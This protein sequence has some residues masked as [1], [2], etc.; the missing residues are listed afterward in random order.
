[1]IWEA[2]LWQHYVGY[3]LI[4]HFMFCLQKEKSSLDLLRCYIRISQLLWRLLIFIYACLI[5][6][7][8]KL[9][10]QSCMSRKKRM[11]GWQPASAECWVLLCCQWSASLAEVGESPASCSCT[12]CW[13]SLECSFIRGNNPNPC[14]ETQTEDLP[15]P[16]PELRVV[17]ALSLPPLC[18]TCVLI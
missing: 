3:F 6:H 13:P 4:P 11:W 16:K 18:P 1:M 14:L 9:K 2:S 10:I 5:A 12:C 8:K 17:G 15:E 7:T